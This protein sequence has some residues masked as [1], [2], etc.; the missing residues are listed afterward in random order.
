MCK[1]S[2]KYD[3]NFEN[4][5]LREILKCKKSFD[6]PYLKQPQEKHNLENHLQAKFWAIRVFQ[7]F[8]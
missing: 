3:Y 6:D 5:Q 7:V 2:K 1:D 8:F 4:Y